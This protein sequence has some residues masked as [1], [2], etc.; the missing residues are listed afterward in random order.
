[1]LP[2]LE[3]RV[4]TNIIWNTSAWEI[5]LYTFI[6]L[7]VQLFVISI[8][9]NGIVYILDY[10][11]FI[12]Q[13]VPGFVIGRFSVGFCIFG[14]P[15]SFLCVSTFLFFWLWAHLEFFFFFL[16][17]VLELTMSPRSPGSF[18]CIKAI[19]SIWT[20]GVFLAFCVSLLL[21]PLKE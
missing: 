1:M 13:I 5:C 7:F 8:W 3:S 16:T 17:I 20:L 21:N 19:S 11:Y 15:L 6:Y 4:C 2:F 9:T 18:Y 12:A 10:N 14:L